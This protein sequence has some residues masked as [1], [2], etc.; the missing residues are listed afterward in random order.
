VGLGCVGKPKLAVAILAI[1]GDCRGA[2]VLVYGSVGRVDSGGAELGAE[3]IVRRD[4][5]PLL[6]DAHDAAAAKLKGHEL[7][8]GESAA[9]ETTQTLVGLGQAR[10]RPRAARDLCARAT[11]EAA[12]HHAGARELD[13]HYFVRVRCGGRGLLARATL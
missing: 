11:D 12:A 10:E 3:V 13:A 5:S 4:D 1:D 9:A 2:P 8:T 7:I 6:V